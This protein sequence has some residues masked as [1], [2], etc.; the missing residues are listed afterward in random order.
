MVIVSGEFEEKQGLD[1]DV[2]GDGKVTVTDALL[3]LQNSVNKIEFTNEQISAA[4]LDKDGNVT[5]T[6]A[7]LALQI[8]VGKI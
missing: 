7:L 1:G 4:D 8:S 6:D 2:D 5:V 3:I